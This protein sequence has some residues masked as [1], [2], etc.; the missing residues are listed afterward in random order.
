MR[1]ETSNEDRHSPFG[2]GRRTIASLLVLTL[3]YLGARLSQNSS[4]GEAPQAGMKAILEGPFHEGG[5][6]VAALELGYEQAELSFIKAT[7]APFHAPRL[8]EN[9]AIFQ[10][11]LQRVGEAPRVVEFNVP[12]LI[13]PKLNDLTDERGEL[14]LGDEIFARTIGTLVKLPAILPP[15]ELA[16]L[17]PDGHEL[18]R[19]AVDSR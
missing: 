15:F 8:R 10:A 1:D 9:E 17:N 11:R 14:R 18:L 6:I 2:L 4:V 7:D 5:Q 19:C 3:I 13:E 12:G 16:I